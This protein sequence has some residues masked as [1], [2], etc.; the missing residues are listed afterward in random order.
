MI[1]RPPLLF[2]VIGADHNHIEAMIRCV[3]NA[4][5]AMAAWHV[6]DDRIAA[7]FAKRHGQA[8]RVADSRAILED[9]RIDL[10][11]SAAV[12][13]RRASIAI[14]AMQHGKHA[15]VD[16]P[17]ATTAP[18]LAALR[19]VQAETGRRFLVYFTER[20]EVG[21][22]QRATDLVRAGAI[23]RV[24]Q[25]VGLGPHRLG[26]VPRPAWFFDRARHGG[27]LTDLAS[28]QMDHFLH[29]TGSTR[30][31]VVAAQAGNLAHPD[32]DGLQDFGE[33]MVRGN[34]GTGYCRVDWFTPDGLAHW[35]D[36][37]LTILGTHG[38]IEVHKN[39]GL[40]RHVGGSHLTLIDQ[41]QV[42]RIDGGGE[43]LRFGSDLLG[44]L[45]NS[46]ETAQAQAQCFL[47]CDLALQAQTQA[48]VLDANRAGH[49]A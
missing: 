18:Q 22:M 6:D 8:P 39:I 11:L 7:D 44:D 41:E 33:A 21:A 42:R 9:S 27:I 14:E 30:A 15:M 40:D 49:R 32:H 1:D 47:A 23:G 24:L 16:K 31:E 37:R 13:D 5:G 12:P 2:A 10:I 20:F 46:T 19:R 34:G 25:T 45:A 43:T 28:H 48:A 35:G 38:T 17:G 3:T 36:G 26:V 29:Y 4:G